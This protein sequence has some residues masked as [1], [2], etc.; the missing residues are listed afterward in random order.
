MRW[1]ATLYQTQHDFVARY[2]ASLLELVPEGAGTALD[3]GCGTGE[4]TEALARRAGAAI[5][6]DHSPQMVQAAR[7]A[8][9]GLRFALADGCALP[10]QEAFDVVFSNAVFH[11]VTNQAALL[12]SVH[13]VLKPG[14]VLVCEFGAKGNIGSMQAAFTQALARRGLDWPSPF[15][16]PSADEYGRQLVDAG[17]EPQLV[18]EYDRPT[19]LKGGETGLRL[20][21]IQFFAGA[22]AT[23]PPGVANDVLAETEQALRSAL[24]QGDGW[25]ADYRRLRCVARKPGVVGESEM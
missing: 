9:P 21:M 19:P 1:D 6:V 16:F 17:F 5:G 20:W 2:G 15:F 3:L 12:A 4:L 13:R 8:H 23:L 11:W 25:V 14:G 22:L 24:W 7:R 10:W 18:R